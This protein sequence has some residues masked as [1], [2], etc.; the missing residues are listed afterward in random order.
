[1]PK[2]KRIVVRDVGASNGEE[3]ALWPEK[4]KRELLAIITRLDCGWR[5]NNFRQFGLA[6]KFDKVPKAPK[7]TDWKRLVRHNRDVWSEWNQIVQS[8][9]IRD[10]VPRRIGSSTFTFSSKRRMTLHVQVALTATSAT[11]GKT[12]RG[13]TE[14]FLQFFRRYKRPGTTCLRVVHWDLPLHEI[15]SS[16]K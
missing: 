7:S 10:F 12:W 9:E 1:M 13:R 11:T 16:V 2:G 3:W 4:R 15:L 6:W 8:V 14:L 5:E